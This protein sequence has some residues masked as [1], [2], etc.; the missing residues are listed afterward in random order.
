MAEDKAIIATPTGVVIQGKESGALPP[1]PVKTDASRPAWLPE[2]FK[3]A[4]DLAKSYTEL[5]K[6]LGSSGAPKK[7]DE[8]VVEQPKQGEPSALQIEANKA[9]AKAGLDMKA[10]QAE[11]IAKGDLTPESKKA[12]A[13]AGIGEEQIKVYQRG[14]EAERQDYETKILDG[15]EGGRETFN[16]ALKWAAENLTAEEQAS[17]NKAVELGDPNIGKLAVQGLLSQYQKADG[18]RLVS[19]QRITGDQGDVFRSQQQ[20]VAAQSDKRYSTDPAYRAEVEA[21]I[22]RSDFSKFHH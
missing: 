21:K 19:G 13:D 8:P 14:M 5:E 3:S 18:P 10:L 17:F 9:V 1:E 2:K 15:V 6:K 16:E 11:Y 4:E 7:A 20:M 12:L 22:L